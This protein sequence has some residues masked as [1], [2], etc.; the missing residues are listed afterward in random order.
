MVVV[1]AVIE[2]TEADVLALTE[3]VGVMEMASRAEPGCED[4]TFSVELSNPSMLRITERWTS[5]EALKA[6]FET[7]HMVDFQKA[8]AA[9]P[10]KNL[11]V[12]FYDAQEMPSPV[13]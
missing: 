12:K 1:N 4:Y 2:S 3:A 5:L 9:H 7:E 10:P 6:H 8:I 13:G 11:D